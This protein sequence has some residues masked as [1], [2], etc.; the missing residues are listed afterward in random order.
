MV[1]RFTSD[2]GDL[3]GEHAKMNKGNPYRTSA[4]IPFIL[5]YPA[6]VKPGKIVKSATTSVDFAPTILSLMGLQRPKKESHG[7]NVAY[8]VL[9]NKSVINNGRV[10]YMFDA[11]K[12]VEWAAAF[13]NQYKV[14][15]SAKDVPWLFDL[16]KDPNELINYFDHPDYLKIREQ[17]L[18]KLAKAIKEFR[19]PLVKKHKHLL[20]STPICLDSNDRVSLSTSSS[21]TVATC[22][23]LGV[24]IS[25]NNCSQQHW[26]QACPV[27]C[28]N[29]CKD[30]EGSIWIKGLLKTC[31][32]IPNSGC[33]NSKI[34]SFCP[35]K[36]GKCTTGE[37]I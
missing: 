3:L 22:S 11:G 29:C 23:D 30:S 31:M 28:G 17:L 26:K 8:E 35:Q 18:K 14:I 2:H 37:A 13:R 20:W 1:S 9:S 25:L 10:R 34:G 33:N 12:N 7:F 19:I 6:K 4:G 16:D 27:T 32:E 5:R 21:S 36:C 24:S 15:I